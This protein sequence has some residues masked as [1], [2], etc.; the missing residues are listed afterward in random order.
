MIAIQY[1]LLLVAAAGADAPPRPAESIEIP[2]LI[3]LD[4]QVEISVREAGVLAEVS[5]KE[6]QS[7]KSGDPIA[8]VDDTEAKSVEERAKFELEIANLKAANTVNVR[9]AQKTAEVARAELNRSKESN[10]KYK[11]SISETE[12]DR[13]RLIVENGQLEVE[14][15]EEEI[16]VAAVTSRLKESE[17]RAAKL[18]VER[19]AVVAPLDGVVVQIKR[20]VGEW[21]E[22]GDTVARILRL[23]RLRAEGFVKLQSRS[24]RLLGSPV[25]LIVDQLPSKSQEFNGRVVFVD[26]EIDPVNAQVRI[27]AEVDNKGLLLQPGM[28]ARMILDLSAAKP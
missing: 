14:R 9:F 25:K 1:L 19:H 22:P 8:R 24:E 2:S 20:H 21:V 16:K 15:A 17:H 7:I 27:W 3:R 18:R 28:R 11:K 4:E 23:D 10:E 26:P 6:G 12:M 5:V 13:L